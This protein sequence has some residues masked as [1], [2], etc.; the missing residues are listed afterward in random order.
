M[1]GSLFEI[2]IFAGYI[3]GR[4]GDFLIHSRHYRALR[5]FDACEA[6]PWTMRIFYLYDLLLPVALLALA[7][8]THPVKLSRVSLS[9]AMLLLS[10]G[11]C[12][13]VWA[14]MSL[15]SLWT[16]RCL[17]LS[18]VQES[19]T[20]PF[21]F[22][23]HPE[24]F[25]RTVEACALTFCLGLPK[26]ILIVLITYMLFIRQIAVLEGRVKR[27]GLETRDLQSYRA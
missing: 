5:L 22:M 8:Q 19:K 4:S 15:G 11:F 1:S 2:L 18:G 25:A 13:R 9:L 26:V 10:T 12:L 16:M 14:I 21:R 20:G 3:I 7:M 27:E 6:S 17:R 23:K 24:Y